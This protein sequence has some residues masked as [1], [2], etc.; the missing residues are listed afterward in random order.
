MGPASPKVAACLEGAVHRTSGKAQVSLL[1]GSVRTFCLCFSTRLQA[2]FRIQV[3]RIKVFLC[4]RAGSVRIFSFE[5]DTILFAGWR[6]LTNN[7]FGGSACTLS[8]WVQF[9]VF[10]PFCY[11]AALDTS[12]L[13]LIFRIHVG[14]IIIINVD[15]GLVVNDMSEVSRGRNGCPHNNHSCL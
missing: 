2:S 9:T 6:K 3:I 7:S 15:V 4:C 11:S 14:I 10:H 1:P 8:H 12:T 5:V 13:L